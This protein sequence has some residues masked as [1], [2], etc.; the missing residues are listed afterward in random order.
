MVQGT[1]GYLDPVYFYTSHTIEKSGVYSFDVILLELLTRKKPFP[2]MTSKGD[3]L[4]ANFVILLAEG[5]LSHMLNPRVIKEGGKEVEVAKIVVA[6]VK[7][8]GEDRPTMR[9]VELTLEGFQTSTKHVV[10]R[11]MTEMLIR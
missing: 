11:P 10:V 7:F 9:Q 5:N 8:K 2:S 4:V 1:I 3:S 6:C